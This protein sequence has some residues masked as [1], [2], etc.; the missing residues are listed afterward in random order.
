MHTAFLD[1]IRKLK[2]QKMTLIR[3]SIKSAPRHRFTPILLDTIGAT[4]VP[5]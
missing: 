3:P 4:T 5:F 2:L 1:F